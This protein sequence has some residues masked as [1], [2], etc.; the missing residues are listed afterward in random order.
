MTASREAAAASRQERSDIETALAERE[1]DLAALRER[2]DAA[3]PAEGGALTLLDSR[4]G[5]DAGKTGDTETL[6]GRA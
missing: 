6:C 2:L 1:A 3:A 4:E 5:G